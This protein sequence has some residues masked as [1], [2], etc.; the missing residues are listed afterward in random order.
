LVAIS[1]RSRGSAKGPKWATNTPLDNGSHIYV[2]NRGNNTILRM[3][4]DDNVI[5]VAVSLSATAARQCP[6]QRDHYLD[7][8]HDDLRDPHGPEQWVGGVLALPAF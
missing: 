1:G 8:R 4:Q 7:R 6:P 3:H 2:A 5:A